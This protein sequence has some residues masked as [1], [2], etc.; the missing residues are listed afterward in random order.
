M[1][2]LLL[3]V[4]AMCCTEL[5]VSALLVPLLEGAAPFCEPELGAFSP[6]VPLADDVPMVPVT[7]TSWPTCC[8]SWLVSPLSVYM[9]PVV[10]WVRV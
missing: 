8:C 10:S 4:S 7:W 9:V 5:T 6:E 2:L 3:Q 1:P